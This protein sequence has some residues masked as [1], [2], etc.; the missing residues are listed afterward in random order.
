MNVDVVDSVTVVYKEELGMLRAQAHSMQQYW[1]TPGQITIIVNDDRLSESDIDLSWWGVH[2]DHVRIIH[3]D[4]WFTKT[5]LVGWVE[6]QVLKILAAT[7]N[8]NYW[9]IILDAKTLFVNKFNNREYI[10]SD[11]KIKSGWLKIQPVFTESK[12]ITNQIFDIDS[13]LVAGPAG[14]PFW[15]EN[16][17]CKELINFIE[18]KF[19]QTLI[20]FWVDHGKLTEFILYSGFIT[21][22][23]GNINMRY[24][25]NVQF[26]VCNI[27]HYEYLDFEQKFKNMQD[28]STLTVSIDQ[29][30]WTLITD[31]QKKEFNNFLESRKLISY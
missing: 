1:A 14:V 30:A 3:R 21:Y 28:S 15:V 22:K 7:E 11:N 20:N 10:T 18:N 16:N 9:S 13:D 12:N 25:D 5:K 24:N 23:F 27:A 6:Q 2:R 19:R 17:L 26:S 29:K 4:K 8:P 31:A